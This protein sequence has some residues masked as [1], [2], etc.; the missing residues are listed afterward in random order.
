MRPGERT[1]TLADGRQVSSW[2][3]DWRHECEARFILAM[4]TLRK[5]RAILYGETE[6]LRISG[7]W[8]TKLAYRGIKQTRGEAEVARLERTMMALWRAGKEEGQK[9]A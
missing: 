8:I 6:S 4:P 9:S 3:E 2:S 5:R 1:V 7:K